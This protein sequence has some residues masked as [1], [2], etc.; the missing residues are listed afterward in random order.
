[1]SKK[2]TAEQAAPSESAA[3]TEQPSEQPKVESNGQS[4]IV[5]W[6]SYKSP[7]H[8][9]LI[10]VLDDKGEV[11]RDGKGEL[12][13]VATKFNRFR[14]ECN[15]SDWR[16]KNVDKALELASHAGVTRILDVPFK[17][18]KK[19]EQ[20]AVMLDS[21]AADE[22]GFGTRAIQGL[23]TMAQLRTA[24]IDPLKPNPVAL[25]LLALDTKS[26]EKI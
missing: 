11:S 22:S 21:L 7:T 9:L 20:F 8:A 19:R 1:M 4:S 26:L 2:Q 13:T 25:K 12:M 3:T 17:D 16:E 6:W 10:P 14:K 5:T 18:R 15:L 24:G 23:F